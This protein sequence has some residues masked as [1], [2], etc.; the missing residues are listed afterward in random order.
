MALGATRGRV[1]RGIM[2]EGALIS[3]AGEAVGVAGSL[4]CMRFIGDLLF[5]VSPTDLATYVGIPSALFA[6]ALCATP[7]P[8][9]RATRVDPMVALRYE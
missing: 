2:R 5:G 3:A 8:A 4:A 6:V 1:L 9:R 7:I